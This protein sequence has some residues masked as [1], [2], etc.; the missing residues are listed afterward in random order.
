MPHK[1]CQCL[2]MTSGPL[3]EGWRCNLG[4][5][6]SNMTMQDIDS[7]SSVNSVISVWT[8]Q[9]EQTDISNRNR[10]HWSQGLHSRYVRVAPQ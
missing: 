9:T 1:G 3:L 10:G 5:S 2:R 4:H 6:V 8:E 7:V